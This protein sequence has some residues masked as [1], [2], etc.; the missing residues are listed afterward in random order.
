MI[1]ENGIVTQSNRST[2]WIKTI[3]SGACEGCSSKESCGTSHNAKAMIVTVKNT[4]AV[5]KG[6]QVVIGLETKPMMFLTFLLYVFPILLLIGGAIIGDSLAPLLEM[7]R[8]LCAMVLGFGFFGAAFLV[9]RKKHTTLTQK[10]EFK[11]F[12]VR[13]KRLSDSGSCQAS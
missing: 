11:P 12:L 9:I 1:T 8:S 7:N 10:D 3:R 4:L 2:A 13:K 6:D 5:E